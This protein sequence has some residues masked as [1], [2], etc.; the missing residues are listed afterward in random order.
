MILTFKPFLLEFKHPFGVSSNVR[1]HTPTVF[2]RIEHKG[3]FGYGEACLP[4]YLGDTTEDTLLF[5]EKVK[6]IID[7]LDSSFD[8]KEVFHQ[9]D[10][11][12]E[13][14]NPAKAAIDIAISDLR[15]KISEKP[16]YELMGF[17]K[18]VPV[19]T[20]CTIGIDDAEMIEQKIQEA[21]E[22]SIL[23]VKAG[24]ADDK[25][26]IET[27]RKYTN[28]PLYVDV[29]QGWKDK[30]F[31]LQM[32]EWLHTKNVLMVEQPMPVEMA[33]EMHWVTSKSQLPTIADESVKRLKDM[34]KAKGVFTGV[35]IKLM[36]S[37]GLTGAR[38]M[39]TYAKQNDMEIMLGCMAESSCATSAMA[40]FMKSADYI[41][42]DAPNLIKND[43][44]R[45]VLYND[46]KVILNDLPGI[47]VE[48]KD[49]GFFD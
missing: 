13:G 47:G 27:I 19:A 24:T 37:A 15:G 22:F 6:G 32:L 10:C 17:G 2:T 14:N 34:E 31:V 48:L 8:P 41:D 5:L 25:K 46:G 43:P 49:A 4:E 38:E 26:L 18:S 42:L 29:N 35:N 3:L 33:E 12:S 9:I 30:K 28:K 20:S 21:D 7:A 11:I 23:K 44:F 16:F 40:Q 36:K 1:T 39:I 45:G